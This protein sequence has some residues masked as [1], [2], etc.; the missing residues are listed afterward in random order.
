MRYIFNNIALPDSNTNEAASHGF[1]KYRIKPKNT[2]TVSD[3][4][5]NLA[6]I[7]FDYNVPIITNTALTRIVTPTGLN[8]KDNTFFKIFPNPASDRITIALN[9][10]HTKKLTIGLYNIFGQHINQLYDGPAEQEISFSIE[11]L[12]AGMYVIKISG[13]KTYYS[14]FI[15]K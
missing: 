4:I 6:G 5:T 10:F 7:I 9:D 11:S 1:I 3:S 2:L 15:K 13:E 8:E 14:R 12:P